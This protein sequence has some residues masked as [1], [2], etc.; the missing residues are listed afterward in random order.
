[1][2]VRGFTLI[3][4]LVVL[5]IFSLVSVMAYGGLNTVLKARARIEESLARTAALQKTYQ[6]L[7]DDFQQVRPRPVRDVYGQ[8]RAA[9]IGIREPRIEITRAGWR[10]PLLQPRTGLERVSYRL[11]E[12]KLIRESYRVLD[13]AQNSEPVSVTLLDGIEALR[14][15]YLNASREWADEWPPPSSTGGQATPQS[16]PPLAVE[17][18][19]ETQNEGDLVYL[20]RLGLDALPAGFAGGQVPGGTVKPPGTDTKPPANE[21]TVTP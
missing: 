1:M 14:L 10:N 13:Q 4:L 12:N 15:R 7:R 16:P 8:L 3:E 5:V 11:D 18:T 6:R 21:E 20:F 19:L 9:V 2:K 17:I